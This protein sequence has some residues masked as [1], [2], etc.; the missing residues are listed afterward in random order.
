MSEYTTVDIH[1]KKNLMKPHLKFK[2]SHD[3]GPSETPF[4]HEIENL[5]PDLTKLGRNRH[6]AKCVIKNF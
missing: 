1:S 4:R 3:R 6:F 2:A 5:F